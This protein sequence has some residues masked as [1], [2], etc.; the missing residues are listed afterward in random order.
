M[1]LLVSCRFVCMSTDTSIAIYRKMW[2]IMLVLE[3]KWGL[4]DF[5]LTISA[6]D[7]VGFIR[8]GSTNWSADQAAKLIAN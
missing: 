3:L 6:K 7:L 4:L 8:P 1:N 5:R 2:N